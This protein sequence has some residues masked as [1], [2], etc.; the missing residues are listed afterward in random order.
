M[1]LVYVY[2]LLLRGLQI[3]AVWGAA[4][5][6]QGLKHTRVTPST[7]HARPGAEP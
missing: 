3:W 4:G 1:Q 7:N 5:D 6:R 2:A